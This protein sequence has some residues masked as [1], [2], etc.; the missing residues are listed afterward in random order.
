MRDIS[1][2][3]LSAYEDLHLIL[4][5]KTITTP[6]IKAITVD[7]P[8]GD[9]VLDFTE[10]FGEIN[11]NNRKLTLEFSTIFKQKEFLNLF[12]YIQNVLHGKKMKVYLSDDP[13]FYY[14]GRVSVNEWKSNK[15]IGK[16]VIEVD[17]EPYK[18]KEAVTTVSSTVNSKS[19][20]ICSN[21]H[22]W[23]VPKIT[24]SDEVSISFGEYTKVLAAGE[25][26]DDD[27]IFT[28]GSNVLTVTPTR[29]SANIKIEYQ[30]RGL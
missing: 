2:N 23:V 1:F 3:E 12:S 27:I 26:I 15:R 22:K 20:I 5:I 28:E 9:G 19:N 7:I 29:D 16:L 13:G 21:L 17:A 8:G 18:Y 14:Y 25:Y 4:E 24:V 6:S 11:Y 10:Y 30:E